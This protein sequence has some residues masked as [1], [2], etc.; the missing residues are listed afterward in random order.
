MVH[1]K[2]PTVPAISAALADG[3]FYASTGVTL[4]N[5]DVNGTRIRIE[6]D[7]ADRIIASTIHQKRFAIVDQ[8]RIGVDLMDYP[9]VEKY[10]R[11]ECLGH[12]EQFA[13]TQPFFIEK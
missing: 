13:W 9:E 12:G 11:F 6:T 5:I 10:V 1:V 7:N 3:R 4:R 2:E 8:S